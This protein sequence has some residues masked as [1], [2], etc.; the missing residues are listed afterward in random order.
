MKLPVL[1]G[2]FQTEECILRV[3]K[4]KIPGGNTFIGYH[5]DIKGNHELSKDKKI[6]L[7]VFLQII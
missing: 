3:N 6:F 4:S 5:F 1:F 7:W 2:I